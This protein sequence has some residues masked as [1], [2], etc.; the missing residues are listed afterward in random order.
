MKAA[1]W[2]LALLFAVGASAVAAQEKNADRIASGK[3]LYEYHCVACHG[4]APGFPPFPELP[5]TA[6]LRMR[7]GTDRPALLT[8][9]TDL[10][11]AFVAYFVRNGISVMPFFRKTEI[12]DTELGAI[13]AFLSRNNKDE[14]SK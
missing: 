3:Q 12:S 6:A 2:P 4:A 5:G 14:S 8:E 10:T 11:P 1:S 13:G 9:R 7:Y